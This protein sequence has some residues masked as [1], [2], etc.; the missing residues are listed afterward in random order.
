MCNEC[1]I[2]SRKSQKF[3]GNSCRVK[4]HRLKKKQAKKH[5]GKCCIRCNQPLTDRQQKFCGATCKQLEFRAKKR[6]TVTQYQQL[7]IKLSTVLD[8]I[9]LV[10][11]SKSTMALEQLGYT[12]S[13]NQ[14]RWVGQ[15]MT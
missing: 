13:V 11:M 5:N 9:E 6:A 4:A 10:G 12:Y 15:V 3:C 1:F 7:G 2:P 14:K 8:S